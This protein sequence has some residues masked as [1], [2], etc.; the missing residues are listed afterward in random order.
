MRHYYSSLLLLLFTL[1]NGTLASYVTHPNINFDPLEQL[2]ISGTYNGI[3]LYKDTKQLTSLP[4]LTSSVISLSN[5][6]LQLLGS[7]SIDGS[8]YDA[9]IFKNTLIFGG[10]FTTMGDQ[11]VKNIASIDLT[12]HQLKPLSKGLD[13][14][15]HSIYCDTDQVYVG[16]SF[17][18]PSTS[19]SVSYST[20]LSQFGGNVALWKGEKWVGLPWKGLNGPVYSILKN[21]NQ[22][23]FGGR[24]DTTTDGQSLHAPASQPISLPATGVSATSGLNP[25]SILCSSS[26][27]LL[28]EGVQ[29]TWQTAFST[30]SVNPSLVRIA[31]SK[32]E[33][34]QTKEFSIRSLANTTQLFSLSYL[35][36]I[37]GIAVTCSDNC[38]LSNNPSVTYQDFRIL[39]TFMT[40]GIA[41]DIKSWYGVGGGLSF[42]QVFQSE[43][44]TYAV[45]PDP[46]NICTSNVTLPKVSTVG[47]WTTVTSGSPY[48]SYP[49]KSTLNTSSITFYPNIAESGIYEVLVYTPP[50]KSTACSERTDIDLTFALSK[51]NK[52]NATMSQKYPG[53][54]SIF[55]GY[56]DLSDN[57]NPSI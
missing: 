57:Y 47:N 19:D 48:L 52:E 13:G 26:S 53:S 16:G 22:I 56:F 31:N 2:T 11:S 8:I 6:T 39:D 25:S 41:I 32:V 33:N 5:D 15:V 29:G 46:T 7:S 1:L 49:I 21:K 3:S 34:R 55:T 28:D 10:N 43:I 4:P 44:F 40:T 18:A 30:Y 54:R 23:V 35:D 24:F 20:S 37:T 12:T 38:T 50:C 27:W 42:V 9:C 17:T 36:P 14:I 51:A 45:N